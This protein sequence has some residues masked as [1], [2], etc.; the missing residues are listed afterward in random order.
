MCNI[1]FFRYYRS[2]KFVRHLE[3]FLLEPKVLYSVTQP[4]R[5]YL[6]VNFTFV[7][8]SRWKNEKKKNLKSVDAFLLPGNRHREWVKQCQGPHSCTALIPAASRLRCGMASNSLVYMHPPFLWALPYDC[9]HLPPAIATEGRSICH[10]YLL[11]S[12]GI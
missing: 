6:H 12:L 5:Y 9:C 3:L 11:F 10:S 4:V 1:D 8:F 2:F 7:I